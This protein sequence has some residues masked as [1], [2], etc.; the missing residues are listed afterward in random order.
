MGNTNRTVIVLIHNLNVMLEITYINSSEAIIQ[1]NP[2]R[3]QC[4]EEDLA[5]GHI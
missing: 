1:S 5:N 3:A 4:S 2:W